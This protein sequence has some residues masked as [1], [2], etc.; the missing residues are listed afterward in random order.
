MR[1]LPLTH[2]PHASISTPLLSL[3]DTPP[4]AAMALSRVIKQGARQTFGRQLPT[5]ASPFDSIFTR[6]HTSY[7][8]QQEKTGRPVSP[9]VNVYLKHNSFPLVAIS[10]ILNRGTAAGLT[11]GTSPK[12][13]G[14]GARRDEWGRRGGGLNRAE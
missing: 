7:S 3:S 6:D 11:F 1:G 2:F 10:S 5:A 12:T 13:K 8:E 4:A 14:E 9:H